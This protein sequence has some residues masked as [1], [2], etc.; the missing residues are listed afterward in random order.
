MTEE[1]LKK[2]F[3]SKHV[4]AA[5]DATEAKVGASEAIYNRRAVP[6]LSLLCLKN[7]GPT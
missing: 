1:L 6:P 5:L 3:A 7:T 4:Q 2:G